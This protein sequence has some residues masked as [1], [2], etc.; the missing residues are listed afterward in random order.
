VTIETEASAAVVNTPHSA[1]LQFGQRSRSL[2]NRS[3]SAITSGLRRIGTMINIKDPDDYQGRY[4][5][6]VDTRADTICAGKAFVCLHYSGRIVDIGGFHNDLGPLTGIPIARV[7]TAYD[8]PSGDT[9]II[10]ANEALFFGKHLEHSLL[11][12]QQISDNG[13]RCDPLP[14]QYNAS[15]IHGISDP[16]TNSTL[17]FALHGCISYLPVRLPT[18]QELQTCQYIELTSE[19]PWNPYDSR[20]QLQET[21]FVNQ[22]PSFRI[23][24]A[25]SSMERRS[26]VD[27]PTLARRWG[28]SL[29][30]ATATLQSTT[31]RGIRYYA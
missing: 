30:T 21:A 11:S 5:A 7:A 16:V 1:S 14:R 15:S 10:A 28:T 12:P 31:Q 8:A 24:A 9:F 26:E 17:P 29:E 18:E 2:N 25:S 19:L 3:Q 13:L 27:A 23:Q 20:F 22:T 6:E 4:R